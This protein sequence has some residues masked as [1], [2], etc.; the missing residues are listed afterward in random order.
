MVTNLKGEKKMSIKL[1][2]SQVMACNLLAT[3]MKTS[4]ILEK[5]KIRPETLSR[6]KQN[7]EFINILKKTQEKILEA[8]INSQK[9][10][11]ILSQDI[12]INALNNDKLDEFKKAT[13]ALG[14]IALMRG[15]NNVEDKYT[16]QLSDLNFENSFGF[17]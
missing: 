10:I 12:I 4:D 17:K 2:E 5:L 1:N 6:W 7:E 16:K 15:K 13:I 14:Y 9:H 11:L 8:I 3:G